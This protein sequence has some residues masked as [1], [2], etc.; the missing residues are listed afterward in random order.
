[1][2]GVQE[3]H[4][5][6]QSPFFQKLKAVQSRHTGNV[7]RNLR[8]R[9]SISYSSYIEVEEKMD[10]PIYLS[11]NVITGEDEMAQ[12]LY[13]VSKLYH[14]WA[15]KE[16]ISKRSMSR[17]WHGEREDFIYQ[18]RIDM[19]KAWENGIKKARKMLQSQKFKMF[20]NEKIIKR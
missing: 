15:K 4:F 10:E 16:N 8:S 1:M 11:K 17:Y 6:S 7:H 20:M 19:T 3:K 12:M 2:G 14:K 18:K 9:D 5:Y 13:N